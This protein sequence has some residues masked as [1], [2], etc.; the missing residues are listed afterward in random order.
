[1][2][3]STCRAG[4]W[5]HAP[6][7]RS[8]PRGPQALIALLLGT[9][10]LGALAACG[11]T[12]TP[13]VSIATY[14]P[15][16]G[17]ESAVGQ[18]MQRAVDLAV[19]QNAKLAGGYALTTLHF[20]EA[21]DDPK[22]VATTLS[23]NT[24]VMGLVGPMGASSV[25]TMLPTL[26]GA[27]LVTIAPGA[28][29]G[30]L[31]SGTAGAATSSTAQANVLLRLAPSD[32]ATGTLAAD[33][34]VRS[35][36]DHGLGAHA[37]YV[38]SDG[39]PS[40]TALAAAFAQEL[41]AR[42][43]SVAGQQ[44]LTF[45]SASNAQAITSAVVEA[46][47]DLVFYGGGSAGAVLLRSTLT[48][49]GVGAMPV[50]IAGP[51]TDTPDWSTQV[52]NPLAGLNTTGLLAAPDPST[53]AGAKSFATAYAAAYPNAAMPPESVLAYDG[54]MDEITA[55]KGLLAAGKPVTRAAVLAAVAGGK[56]AGATGTLA[57]TSAGSLTT[58]LA[59]SLYSTD[60]KGN[61]QFQTALNG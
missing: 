56:Y 1:M 15:V 43:G 14:F 28:L 40:G 26:R 10:L 22:S 46:Y 8:T 6:R 57:F 3:F 37:V 27:G 41:R 47:P 42:G 38:V 36:Q 18:A 20:D 13:T 9:L 32:D 39:S 30:T 52:G 17:P 44:T 7:R 23:G 45:G 12:S 48:Y 4:T 33:V 16:T 59:W 55:I 60:S 31:A 2:K 35:T 5:A 49:S 58:P 61:W 34:A 29:P 25:E 19:K 51:A 54:A 24:Q 53:L 21:S 50:L 11:T